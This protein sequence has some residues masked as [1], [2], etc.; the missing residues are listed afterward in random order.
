MGKKISFLLILFYGVNVCVEA[1]SQKGNSIYG[2]RA[3]DRAGCSVSMPN[4]NTIAVGAYFADSVHTNAGQAQ[5]YTWNGQNWQPKGAPILGEAD[6]DR[7]GNTVVMPDSNTIAVSALLHHA[8]GFEKGQV[9]VFDWKNGMW[10]QKGDDI[11]GS[12]DSSRC[13]N[14]IAM[15]DVN[16]IAT[17]AYNYR[18]AKGEG[19]GHVRIFSWNGTNW[20]QKGAAIEGKNA[21]DFFGNAVSMPDSNTIAIG[22]LQHDENGNNAG[23]VGVWSWNGLGWEQKGEAI[24][25]LASEDRLG[26]AVYMPDKNTLAI[27]S[28]YHD[29]NGTDAGL[30]R[31]YSW[32]GT[33]WEQKGVDLYGD[34]A[35]DRAGWSIRMYHADIIAFGCS[36]SD[37]NGTD[38][39]QVKV[40]QWNGTD[41]IQQGLPINGSSTGDRSGW[42][43]SMPDNYTL[44]IG[45]TFNATNGTESGE[46]RVYTYNSTG[47][48][49]ISSLPQFL[50]YPNPH[51]AVVNILLG[52]VYTHTELIVRNSL[53]VE[54]YRDRFYRNNTYS[55]TPNLATGVYL[56]EII[57]DG[58][59][60]TSKLTVY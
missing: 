19:Q 34:Q 27:G 6:N 32:N 17:A 15:P 16:T 3:G 11:I 41:W 28:P 26:W 56:I 29:G 10:M 22:A 60:V 48:N 8:D 18:G 5:V 44:A 31:I 25:G 46:V 45:A 12:M 14:T 40:Y 38:A 59:R 57:A 55:F 23:Q 49:K 47:L 43:L 42:S 39:G 54:L 37:E 33:R 9:R 1:Q 13:G 7:C 53:G 51:T 2:T 50:I 35:G 24:N 36:G 52:Q 58:D 4:N 20:I 21:G 30:V